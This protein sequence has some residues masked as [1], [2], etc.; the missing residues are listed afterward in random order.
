[1]CG[2]VGMV[3]KANN[4]LVKCTE[5]SFYDMLY[6]DS[7]RGEDSTGVIYVEND[8]SFGYMKEANA[9]T[10]CSELMKNDA[11]VKGMWTRGKALIGHNRKKT[12]G[13]VSDET[14]HPFVVDG[15]FAM[16]HNGTLYNHKTLANTVV[17]SEALTIHLSSVLNADYSK[18]KLEEA[19]G[20]V[21]GAYAIA[22]YNQDTHKVYLTRNKERPLAILE[23]ADGWFWASEGAML[24]WILNRNGINWGNNKVENIKENCL[25]VIDL[26]TNTLT[27]EDYVPKKAIPPTPTKVVGG[28]TITVT[29]TKT[30]TNTVI[31][32]TTSPSR[33]SKNEFKRIKRRYMGGSILMYAQD[34]LEKNFPRTLADGE[35]EIILLGDCEVFQFD[36]SIQ[37]EFDIY[38]SIP[39]VNA[40]TDTYYAGKVLDMTYEASRGYVM[41]TLGELRMIPPS[42][43]RFKHE[44]PVAPLAL[45]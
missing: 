35:N 24:Y 44:T 41:I 42:V 15:K 30:P 22:A 1:M 8:A 7:I 26:E 29:V 2:I 20:K 23:T 43:K 39:G 9:G 37:A 36:H 10:W 32:V 14:A 27:M 17:D 12:I 4:G 28:P 11:A 18:E 6:A 3:N 45:H 40:L 21:S 13:A 25:V 19:L 31:P 16:V 5:D 33:L 38:D 34:Y